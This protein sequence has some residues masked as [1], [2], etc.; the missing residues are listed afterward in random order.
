MRLSVL[1]ELPNIYNGIFEDDSDETENDANESTFKLK[2]KVEYIGGYRPR[3][4][5]F[6]WSSFDLSK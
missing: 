5:L 3:T 2:V 1:N 4:S 6:W